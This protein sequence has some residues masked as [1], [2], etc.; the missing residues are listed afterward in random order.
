MYGA[1][2]CYALLSGYVG[3]SEEKDI[4]IRFDKYAKLWLQVT[5]YSFIITLIAKI[6]LPSEITLGS[7]I[8]ALF[9]VTFGEYWYFCAYETNS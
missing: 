4:N 9:P 3:Y 2:D 5:F 8:K 1:V 7:I 6:F